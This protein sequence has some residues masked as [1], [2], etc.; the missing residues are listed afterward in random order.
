MVPGSW[1]QS[2]I[3]CLCEQLDVLRAVQ[4]PCVGL[5]LIHPKN[6][7]ISGN[8]TPELNRMRKGSGVWNLFHDQISS[9]KR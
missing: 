8:Q 1:I 5:N 6:V 4:L 7:L 2:V 3:F 9:G